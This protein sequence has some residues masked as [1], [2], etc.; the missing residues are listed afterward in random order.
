MRGSNFWLICLAW[1]LTLLVAVS[2]R[3]TMWLIG[4]G[5][6][7]LPKWSETSAR[8]VDAIASTAV[9]QTPAKLKRGFQT[10]LHLAGI[11]SGYG[12]FAPNVPDNF[13][14]VFELHYPDGHVDYKVAGFSGKESE[15]RLASLM[16]FVGRTAS[17]PV[18]EILLKLLAHAIWRQHPE[19]T[20]IRAIL[21]SLSIPSANEFQ[22][23]NKPSYEFLYAYDFVLEETTPPAGRP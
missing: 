21:G 23:G 5:L 8:K 20:M 2:A 7:V 1:H 17:D 12:F 15:L 13:K 19:A 18:R 6:T 9:A 10:Y 3:E 4:H 14:L 22:L 16:D 11:E